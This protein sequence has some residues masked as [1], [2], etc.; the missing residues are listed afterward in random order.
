MELEFTKLEFQ[1]V[2]INSQNTNTVFLCTLCFLFYQNHQCFNFVFLKGRPLIICF[3]TNETKCE[4]NSIQCFKFQIGLTSFCWNLKV[5][6]GGCFIRGVKKK[7]LEIKFS[8]LEFH[9]FFLK[10]STSDNVFSN[11]LLQEDVFLN[12]LL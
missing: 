1:I 4:L 8:K 9:F 7:G 3:L 2:K 11:G 6:N 12:G 10:K 5:R